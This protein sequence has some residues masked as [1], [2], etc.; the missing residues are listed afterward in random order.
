MS[1]KCP[2]CGSKRTYRETARVSVI[3]TV[4]YTEYKERVDAAWSI[5]IDCWH[6]WDGVVADPNAEPYAIYPAG[7][8]PRRDGRR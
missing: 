7:V 3:R 8:I 4:G 5:C 2:N 1:E 6:K